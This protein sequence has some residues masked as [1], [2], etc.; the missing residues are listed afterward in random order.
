MATKIAVYGTLRAGEAN[1]RLMKRAKFVANARTPQRY[2][3]RSM[4]GF[5]CVSKNGASSIAVELY[6]VDDE[7]LGRLDDLEEIVDTT[8]GPAWMYLMP[9]DQRYEQL[10]V[11]KSGDWSMRHES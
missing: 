11:I 8:E 7:T 10:P 9:S 3:M 2:T 5:P 6:E 1:A 4:G